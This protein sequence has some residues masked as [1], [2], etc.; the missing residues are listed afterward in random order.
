MENLV[1]QTQEKGI[2][3]FLK[4][5]VK[6]VVASLSLGATGA[7]G[8]CSTV[9]ASGGSTTVDFSSVTSALTGA[10]SVGQITAVIASVLGA[11]VAFVVIWW[12]SRKLVNGIIGAF[13][14]GKLRF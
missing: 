3:N 2:G 10:F 6:K 4:R 8:V 1:V 14:T 7:M 11:G 9:F 5:N 13:K 12:G